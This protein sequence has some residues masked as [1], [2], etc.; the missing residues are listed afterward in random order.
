M[1]M[2]CCTFLELCNRL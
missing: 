1:T 2:P